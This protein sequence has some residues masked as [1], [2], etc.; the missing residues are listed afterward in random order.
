MF[1]W[2][3]STFD[4]LSQ[5]VAPPPEDGPGRFAYCVQRGEE[6]AAMGCI[7]GMDP[8]HTLINQAKGQY[9]I[10]FACLYSSQ[11][12]LELLIKQPGM[13]IQQTDLAGN[14][15]L[16]Y[17]SMSMA[18]N[19]LDVVKLLIT[20]YGASVVAKNSSGQTPYDV[21]ALNSIRQHLLPIQL[22]AETQAAL[23]NGGQG[24]PAGIDLGGLRIKNPAVPPPPTFAGGASTPVSTAPPLNGS[25]TPSPSNASQVTPAPSSREYSRVG[26]SSAALGG[27]YR[28]DGFHSSSSDVSLQKKYGHSAVGA[29]TNI[30]PPPSSGNSVGTSPTSLAA[31]P[32]AAGG[33]YGA[34]RYVAYGQVAT[35]VPA[36]APATYS[37]IPTTM[38][39]PSSFGAPSRSPSSFGAPAPTPP[40][41]S[42]IH[43]SYGAPTTPYMPL[44]PYQ[45]Q[46][47]SVDPMYNHNAQDPSQQVAPNSAN[48]Y[49]PH[50]Q[51]TA[52]LAEA[53]AQDVFTA[54]SPQKEASTVGPDVLQPAT[55]EG[56][57]TETAASE[58]IHSILPDQWVEAVDPSSGQTYYYNPT[59][60]ETSWTKPTMLPENWVEATDPTSGQIYYYNSVTHETSW[61]K[62]SENASSEM[63]TPVATTF[64]TTEALVAAAPAAPEVSATYAFASQATVAPTS[65]EDAFSSPAP[66]VIEPSATNTFASPEDDAQKSP[67]DAFSSP[68][69]AAAEPSINHEVASPEPEP[70][71]A[72]LPAIPPAH[73]F[74]SPSSAANNSSPFFAPPQR[75]ISADELFA[76]D[77]PLEE[78]SNTPKLETPQKATP[79][80]GTEEL[81]G[82]GTLDDIPLSPDTQQQQQLVAESLPVEMN[83]VA[84]SDD[85]SADALFAAIGMPPPPFSA[86]KPKP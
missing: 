24:L 7:A 56:A 85:N 26:S 70:A 86:R 45:S 8:V 30:A 76:E 10:H 74:S 41:A 51:N 79:V 21:A 52:N 6:D 58:K 81:D 29:Y 48:P 9:P 19:G 36:P 53:N 14:T 57:A 33:R 38:S 80:P 4:K 49:S 13:N 5:H 46:T 39:A 2:A 1:Q 31:N 82:D 11:R 20:N 37:F 62:P 67:E 43:T 22:Q 54:P 15:P 47:M 69:P 17:A 63:A 65:P 35:P 78:N 40:A 75:S 16:H 23:D 72:T 84:I 12:L 50:S 3:Q 44:P 68:P 55:T 73:S 66:V 18:S 59:T 83:V 25:T 77:P 64:S 27:K 71:L 61:E 32:F 28:A 42:S 34:R 60:N